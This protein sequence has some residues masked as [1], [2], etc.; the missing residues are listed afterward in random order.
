MGLLKLKIVTF[1]VHIFFQV[2]HGRLHIFR[3]WWDIARVFYC[4]PL[5]ADPVLGIAKFSWTFFLT[6][7]TFHKYSMWAGFLNSLE[8]FSDDLMSGVREQP[9]VQAWCGEKSGSRT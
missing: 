7:H 2:R 8:M 6:A 3:I 5:T 9:S 1:T 4:T